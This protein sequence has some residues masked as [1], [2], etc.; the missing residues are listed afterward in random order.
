MGLAATSC[1]MIYGSLI[2]MGS[3]TLR[4]LPYFYRP[5]EVVL[6]AGAGAMLFNG[7]ARCVEP[8]TSP[9]WSLYTARV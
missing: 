4:R 1:G 5:W 9:V 8:A 2:I 7:L 6:G 3:N